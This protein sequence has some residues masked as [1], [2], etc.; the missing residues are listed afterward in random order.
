MELFLLSS[1]SQAWSNTVTQENC[2]IRRRHFPWSESCTCIV[3]YVLSWY[4]QVFLGC[5]WNAI[6][7]SNKSCAYTIDLYHITD[8]LLKFDQTHTQNT[9]M[10]RTKQNFQQFSTIFKFMAI[11]HDTLVYESDNCP[12]TNFGLLF[13][14]VCFVFVSG[15]ALHCIRAY[16]GRGSYLMLL[17][18]H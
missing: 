17:S 1:E 2:W 3:L 4:L 8:A 12:R 7:S 15:Q 11:L 13:P 18:V 5:L 6:T 9:P 16:D 14:V 10:K